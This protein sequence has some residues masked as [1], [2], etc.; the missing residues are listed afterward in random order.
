MNTT[1]AMMRGAPKHE[2]A[3]NNRRR[4]A[5]R[6]SRCGWTNSTQ[7]HMRQAP[8]RK[9]VRWI[10]LAVYSDGQES[11]Q[12]CG[13][14]DAAQL[15]ATPRPHVGRRAPACAVSSDVTALSRL[16]K[17]CGWEPPAS[18]SPPNTPLPPGGPGRRLVSSSTRMACVH[19]RARVSSAQRYR[20]DVGTARRVCA[21]V[22]P[23]SP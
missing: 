19:G 8:E 14:D 13:Q 10:G 20:Q 7:S 6:G 11:R 12:P 18:R 15:A 21:S 23:I 2:S 1:I 17:F 5:I 22:S 16:P 3:W 9:K 4:F